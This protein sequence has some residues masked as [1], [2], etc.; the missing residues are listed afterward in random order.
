L[1]F[2]G[3]GL[4][5]PK[6]R[7]SNIQGE[8]MKAK[9]NTGHEKMGGSVAR[10]P[11]AR[12]LTKTE[13]AAARGERSVTWRRLLY[14]PRNEGCGTC[15]CASVLK[16]VKAGAGWRRQGEPAVDTGVAGGA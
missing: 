4:G 16:L 5:S 10:A 8:L 14:E 6:K 1:R 2:L 13:A 15:F 7:P 12:G 11:A 9:H 3:D